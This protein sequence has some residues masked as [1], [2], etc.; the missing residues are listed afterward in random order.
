MYPDN[1]LEKPD[2]ACFNMKVKSHQIKSKETLE[3]RSS[4]IVQEKK[5]GED[6]AAA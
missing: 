3:K 6:E 5:G 2:F 4:C 1:C